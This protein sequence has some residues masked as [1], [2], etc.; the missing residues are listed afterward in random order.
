MSLIKHS[1]AFSIATLLSRVLG[2]VRDALIAYHFGVSHITDAFFIAFRLP[3]TL[4]R[5]F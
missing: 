1:L 3:N 5:L 2:Y 4:R